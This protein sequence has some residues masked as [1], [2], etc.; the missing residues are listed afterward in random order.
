MSLYPQS[1]TNQGMHPNSSFCCFHLWIYS[2]IHQVTWG[3]VRK[4]QKNYNKIPCLLKC[5]Q[6]TN[7]ICNIKNYIFNFS[8]KY[9]HLCF[10]SR[11]MCL[12]MSSTFPKLPLLGTVHKSPSTWTTKQ[13]KNSKFKPQIIE[14]PI[15]IYDAL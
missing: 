1:A 13:N 2:W 12:Q 10:Y 5:N 6:T 8:T 15:P 7:P 11:I 9:I 14:W 3:C 4:L